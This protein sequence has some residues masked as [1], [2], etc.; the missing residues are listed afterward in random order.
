MVSP[1]VPKNPRLLKIACQCF[2]VIPQDI[3]FIN[4]LFYQL[5][6]DGLVTFTTKI[7][8]REILWLRDTLPILIL[9][10]ICKPSSVH[11]HWFVG[12]QTTTETSHNEWNSSLCPV[13][14]RVAVVSLRIRMV[15]LYITQKY[16]K[17]CTLQ[18]H[19]LMIL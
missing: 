18:P 19:D 13:K 3:T 4:V 8:T 11:S 1:T 2:I 6:F 12:M 7:V 17:F 16:D 5:K 14:Q 9:S 15:T 10:F